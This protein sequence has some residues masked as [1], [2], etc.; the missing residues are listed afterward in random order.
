MLKAIEARAAE[1]QKQ[2]KAGRDPVAERDAAAGKAIALTNRKDGET[3]EEVGRDYIDQHKDGWKITRHG[4][5]SDESSQRLRLR[6]RDPSPIAVSS[7]GT[8][9]KANVSH[10]PV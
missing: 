9:I 3:F 4:Q 10:V 1:R 8:W 2:I 6:D 5:Q 7:D